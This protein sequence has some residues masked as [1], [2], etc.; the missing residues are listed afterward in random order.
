MDSGINASGF[1]P[2]QDKARS[3]QE[4]IDGLTLRERGLV[5][6]SVLAV[7]YLFWDALI[8]E[9]IR[10]RAG[11][12]A[13]QLEQL[14]GQVKHLQTE[15]KTLSVVAGIDPDRVQKQQVTQLK[16]ELADID[17]R[18]AELSQGLV[19]A[20]QLPRVLEDVLHSSSELT[21]VKLQTLEVEK[22]ALTT[23]VS[24]EKQVTSPAITEAAEE[25]TDGVFKHSVAITVR[26]S[27]FQVLTYLQ[28]LE[29]LPW[30]F[31]WEWLEYRV[32]DYPR[33]EVV[34]RVYTLSAE[35]GLLG[36]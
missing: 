36:V 28:A 12:L 23:K 31:Y 6:L 34:L 30:G 25:V 1:K 29:A 3:L 13:H 20:D 18:L 5:L 14:Q 10:G 35:E 2:L 15:A 26:G 16:R 11:E 17:K 7:L 19:S 8:M 22:L 32:T 24:A 9:S 27:Y 33:G 21:L 4:K